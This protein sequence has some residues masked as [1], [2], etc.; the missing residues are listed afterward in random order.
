MED[1]HWE[2][3]YRRTHRRPGYRTPVAFAADLK[4]G[5]IA[6]FFFCRPKNRAGHKKAKKPDFNISLFMN[7]RSLGIGTRGSALALWQARWVKFVLEQSYPQLCFEMR[8]I[9]TKGDQILDTAL[10]KI[11]DKGLFTKEIEQQLLDGQIDIAVHSLKDMPTATPEGLQVA[12]ICQRE[13][14][15]DVLV[16]KGQVGLMGL[17]K[18]AVVLTSSI[19]RRAQLLHRRPD[20]EIRDVRGNIPTRLRKFAASEAE[21]MVLAGA[22]LKRLGL[23]DCITERLDPEVFLPACGQGAL[24]I[25]IREEDKEMEAVVSCLNDRASSATARAE[26]TVLAE[27]QGGC[28]VPIGAYAKIANDRL[29]LKGMLSDLQGRR[30][31]RAEAIGSVDDPVALGRHVAG[32]LLAE[33]GQEILHQIMAEVNRIR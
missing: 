17:G 8:V 4:K 11:G 9:E 25:E 20:V 5:L 26:R 10:T 15:A 6:V 28:Q 1:R 2:Y 3:N 29:H 22:G 16:S 14:P 23:E 32:M 24:A 27:L 21:G 33:D 30:L 31:R 7:K 12:A 19:R 13:E 18:G